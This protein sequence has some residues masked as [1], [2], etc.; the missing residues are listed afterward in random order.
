MDM[1]ARRGQQTS[2]DRTGTGLATGIGVFS[3]SL[4][5]A[6][7]AAPRAL[8]RLIG[9]RPDG[10]A[11]GTLRALGAREIAHGVGILSRPRHPIPLW[12]RV[13]G[14]VLDLA[15]LG[16]AMKTRRTHTRRMISTLVAV[17]GVAALDIYAG[18]RV[19]A[20][21]HALEGGHGELV[22]RDTTMTAITVN[23]PITEVAARWRDLAGD[24]PNIK[25]VQFRSAPGGR[26]TEICVEYKTPTLIKKALGRLLHNDAEQLTD[27]DLRKVKQLIELGEIVHSDASIHRGMHSAQPTK[28]GA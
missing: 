18:R 12:A 10:R 13:A 25:N 15:L 1:Q 16:W 14:D 22:K 17:V 6:E 24:L 2:E 23:R 4:G 5:L 26:G 27:G 21:K 28:R 9:V 20:R 3:V 8:A 11:R 7:I 19:Q